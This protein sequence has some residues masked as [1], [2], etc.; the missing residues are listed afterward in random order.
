MENKTMTE[1]ELSQVAGGASEDALYHQV[2]PG[3]T[4]NLI[5]TKYSVSA[6]VLL[7]LNQGDLEMRTGRLIR[8]R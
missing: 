6:A 1:K 8:V 5:M 4:L 2:K 7:K 3:D